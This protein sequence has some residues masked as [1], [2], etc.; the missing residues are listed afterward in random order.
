M[1]GRREAASGA[2][3]K[4][5]RGAAKPSVSGPSIRRM[6]GGR[7]PP[8]APPRGGECGSGACERTVVTPW[9]F[10]KS[11]AVKAWDQQ[12]DKGGVVLVPYESGPAS[13]PEDAGS[14]VEVPPQ[15]FDR[16]V[17]A[18]GEHGLV[19][20]V[21]QAEAGVARAGA[22]PDAG[23][24]GRSVVRNERRASA[25]RR[26]HAT[27]TARAGRGRRP[28]RCAPLRQERTGAGVRGLR[29]GR[30]LP[31]QSTVWTRCVGWPTLKLACRLWC[32]WRSSR[33][34]CS[35]QPSTAEAPNVDACPSRVR[36]RGASGRLLLQ[37]ADKRLVR[38]GDL[39][40]RPVPEVLPTG[41]R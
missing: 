31:R 11:P 25:P 29:P 14:V 36:A 13:D 4:A 20:E 7:S 10:V 9:G 5:A 19:R 28:Q 3:P 40:H 37:P 8:H 17:V 32:S 15:V 22:R 21:V 1:T 26:H 18:V 12:R 33:A 6:E 30:S 16:L 38:I 23:G 39:S 34:C 2:T 24:A 35:Q 41:L 27:Y